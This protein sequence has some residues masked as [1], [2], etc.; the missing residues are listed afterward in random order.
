MSLN[1]ELK[2]RLAALNPSYM[3][4]ENESAQHGGYYEG[5]ESHFKVVIVSQLFN[6]QRLTQRHQHVYQLVGDLLAPQ[7]IHAL[8]L[9]TYTE[10]EWQGQQPQSPAC[11]HAPSSV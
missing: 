5:K 8:A 2:Q 4:I 3:H 11:A 1:H 9:H 7:R 6:E 10:S